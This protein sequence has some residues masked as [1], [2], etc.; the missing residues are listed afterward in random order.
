MVIA[1]ALRGF[2]DLGHLVTPIF[3]PRDRFYLQRCT[4]C[5]IKGIKARGVSKILRHD[6]GTDIVEYQAYRVVENADCNTLSVLRFHSFVV[7]AV[8]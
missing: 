6:R 4:H 1:T 8:A 2:N 3:L 7:V 5:P